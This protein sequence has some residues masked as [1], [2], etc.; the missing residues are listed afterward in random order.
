M[1]GTSKQN[2][3]PVLCYW[4]SWAG[5]PG[6]LVHHRDLICHTAC[7]LSHPLSVW[8][9]TLMG[10][11]Q[12]PL[13]VWPSFLFEGFTHVFPPSCP[14]GM[15]W[16]CTHVWWNGIR[17]LWWLWHPFTVLAVLWFF[18]GFFFFSFFLFSFSFLVLGVKVLAETCWTITLPQSHT[19]G[20]QLHGS[21][22]FK[23]FETQYLRFSSPV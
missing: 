4:C 5:S 7:Q 13:A 6:T 2:T 18:L 14:S 9:V 16:K 11:H 15:L 3:F 10:S 8:L 23:T 21:S 19:P 20:L 17:S 22:I 12:S 1:I